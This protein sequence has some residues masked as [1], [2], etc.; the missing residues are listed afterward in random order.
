MGKEYTIIV[1]SF[2]LVNNNKIC[3]NKKA[4]IKQREKLENE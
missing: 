4:N 2:F 1:Y 3:Y